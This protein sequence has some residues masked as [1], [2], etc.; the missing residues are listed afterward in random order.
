MKNSLELFVRNILDQNINTSSAIF[1]ES[2]AKNIDIYQ[3]NYLKGH[4]GHLAT[5]YPVCLEIL[6]MNN[7]NFFMSNYLHN[8]PPKSENLNGYGDEVFEFLMGREEL[9]EI[10][11]IQFIAKLEWVVWDQVESEITLPSGI[12]ALWNAIS[13]GESTENIEIDENKLENIFFE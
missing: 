10:S 6:G 3:N 11:Y 9:E 8:N 2:S 4:L 13:R 1:K 12:H 7:F 5:V